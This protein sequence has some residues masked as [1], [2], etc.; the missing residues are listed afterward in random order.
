MGLGWPEQRCGRLGETIMTGWRKYVIRAGPLLLLALL[1][2]ARPARAHAVLVEST[3]AAYSAVNGPDISIRLRF[4]VRIEAK[5]SRLSLLLPD[6]LTRALEVDTPPSPDVLTARATGLKP[7][8]Y[9]IRWQVLATDGHIT[10]GE[11]PF[12]VKSS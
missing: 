1:V 3:P 12:T 8:D 11:I 5:R 10:R 2:V 4:N 7:G 6:K 9:R